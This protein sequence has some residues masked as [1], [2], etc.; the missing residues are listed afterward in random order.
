M[1][2]NCAREGHQVRWRHGPEARRILAAQPN[3]IGSIESER[4]QVR[5]MHAGNAERSCS[6]GDDLPK[7]RENPL[8]L[9]FPNEI[10]ATASKPT[11]GRGLHPEVDL[12]R[13]DLLIDRL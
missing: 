6:F 4:R 9:R 12:A 3:H 5:G 10:R 1:A 13:L 7:E 11:E 2:V 8:A